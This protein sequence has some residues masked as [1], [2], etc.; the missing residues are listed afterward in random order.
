MTYLLVVLLTSLVWLLVIKYQ[1]KKLTSKK[2]ELVYLMECHFDI[3]VGDNRV[4]RAGERIPS[5]DPAIRG[6]EHYFSKVSN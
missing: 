3:Y 5:N 6:R 4:I 2:D 1:K